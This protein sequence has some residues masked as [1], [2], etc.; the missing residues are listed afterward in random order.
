MKSDSKI[1]LS[2]VLNYEDYKKFN[3]YVN[4]KTN[5]IMCI[6]YFVV[7]IN[8]MI[9]IYWK[10]FTSAYFIISLGSVFVLLYTQI[11]S[12]V[13][14]KITFKSNTVL[15][16][17]QN[18]S[19][20]ELGMS[21]DSEQID[22]NISWKEILK[23]EEGKETLYIFLTKNQAFIIP[24]RFINKQDVIELKNIYYKYIST[25]GE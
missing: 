25:S 4:R 2:V 16:S 1:N 12:K 17:T 14:Q 8:L 23:I 10:M 5:L 20:N 15:N 19:F 7:I 11:T 21:I 13:R 3:R 22:D 6:V 24:F 18:Y 9:S